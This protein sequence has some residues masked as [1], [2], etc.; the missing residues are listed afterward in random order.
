MKIYTKGGDSGMTSLGNGERTVKNSVYVTCVGGIDELNSHIGYLLSLIDEQD[1]V[2]NKLRRIQN[3]LFEI[4]SCVSLYVDVE[5]G[6]I[7]EFLDQ[8][9]LYLESEID[10]MDADLPRLSAFILPGGS[11]VSA[12]IHIVRSVC[13]RV[14]RS[15][16][17]LP[18][19]PVSVVRYMNRLSDYFFTLARTCQTGQDVHWQKRIR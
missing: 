13:R 10:K 19:R 15:V 17:V 2:H 12:Y 14:E 5:K 7:N 11:Q 6:D 8:E 1:D 18:Q 4:G 9:T 16:V 3:I